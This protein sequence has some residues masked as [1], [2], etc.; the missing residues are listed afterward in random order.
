MVSILFLVIPQLLVFISGM[1]DM[2]MKMASSGIKF[3]P[4]LKEIGHLVRSI[5]IRS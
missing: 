4:D 5:L 2:K 3:I 1:T